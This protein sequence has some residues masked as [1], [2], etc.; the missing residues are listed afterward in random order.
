MKLIPAILPTALLL[1]AAG[2]ATN[3]THPERSDAQ[4]RA[5]VASCSNQANERYQLDPVAALYNAYD[6]LEGMGYQRNRTGLEAFVEENF[7]GRRRA[8][9]PGVRVCQVPCR[10]GISGAR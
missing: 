5:D 6:C 10:D 1:L 9:R 7:A 3:V 4:M 8:A 2:C